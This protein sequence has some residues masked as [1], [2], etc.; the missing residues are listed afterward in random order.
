MV[1]VGNEDPI[2]S[3]LKI[4]P[5]LSLYLTFLFHFFFYFFFLVKKL[6][7]LIARKLRDKVKRNVTNLKKKNKIMP[8]AFMKE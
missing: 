7:S 1:M 6:G 8:I 3:L 5:A 2:I 4:L